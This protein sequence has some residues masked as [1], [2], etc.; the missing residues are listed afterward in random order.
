MNLLCTILACI[1]LVSTFFIASLVKAIFRADPEHG[2]GFSYIPDFTETYFAD[3]IS[4]AETNLEALPSFYRKFP[5]S[6]ANRTLLD[7][8][9]SWPL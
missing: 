5:T 3:G 6:P 4:T 2:T 9:S 8:S 1:F 7:L